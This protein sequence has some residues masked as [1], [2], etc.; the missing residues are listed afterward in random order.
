MIWRWDQGR[1]AYFDYYNIRSIASVLLAFNGEDTNAMDPLFRNELTNATG[2]PFAPSH[3][4]V[5]RNYKRVFES[6]ML[7]TYVGNRLV[8]S[9]IG[10]ALAE[11]DPRFHDPD[12]YLGE[13]ER[14]FRYPYPAFDN[15]S[16]FDG[17]CFPFL[18][19]LKMLFAKAIRH[20]GGGVAL[21]L[22]E[23]GGLLIANHVTGMEDI[24]FYE[25]LR[26][27]PVDFDVE[28]SKDQKR[29]VRE[30]L[31]FVGQ[32]SF[33]KFHNSELIF[34]GMSL[35]ELEKRIGALAPFDTAPV[36]GNSA[37]E[38]F[39]RLTLV[40]RNADETAFENAAFGETD[41]FE[42]SFLAFEGKRVLR[43]HFQIERNGSLRKAFLNAHPE[44][45]CDLC[46]RD[47]RKIYPWTKNLLEVHHLRP[48]SATDKGETRTTELEDVVGLCPSCHR[49]VHLYY[50]LYLQG[51]GKEDFETRTEAEEAYRQAKT[52]VLINV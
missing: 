25:A 51:L 8:V 33:L 26:A 32:H 37:V 42:P 9:D 49:A 5:K 47:M 27:R 20:G 41:V 31:A 40:P 2:L 16:E 35:E 1:R 48:L 45:V 23:V 11:D 44:P 18:A 13:V 12:G 46:G 24:G 34:E 28:R 15:Y 19:I 7:G 14:R 17:V 10:R 21:S 22:D 43:R 39:L 3:Y 30:M 38:D 50:R 52:E 6:S 4:T 36:T 29:Q